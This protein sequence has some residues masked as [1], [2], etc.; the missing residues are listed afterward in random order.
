M[1]EA[2]VQAG[3]THFYPSEWNSDIDNPAIAG[4]RYFRDKH[5]TRAQLA[6]AV[7]EHPDFKYT[8]FITG[9]FTEWT[10]MIGWDHDNNEKREAVVYGDAKNRIGSTS[11]PE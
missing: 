1:V 3:V 2:A 7:K 6:S 4:M 10:L 9:I 11:M 5:A 8:I